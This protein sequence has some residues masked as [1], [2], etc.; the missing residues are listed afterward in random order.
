[1]NDVIQ[2]LT[3][4]ENKVRSTELDARTRLRAQTKGMNIDSNRL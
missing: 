1:M 2:S 4:V 3:R